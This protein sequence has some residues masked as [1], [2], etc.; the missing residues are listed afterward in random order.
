M[1]KTKEVNKL[2]EIWKKIEGYEDLYVV[3]NLGKIKNMVTGRVLKGHINKDGYTVIT[4]TKDKKPKYF[5][6]HR[7]VAIHFIDN[8]DNKAE[9]DHIIP[10]SDGGS[11]CVDNLRWATP[12]ENTNNPISKAKT[13]ASKIGRKPSPKATERAKEVLIID[14]VVGIGKDGDIVIFESAEEA[15][16]NGFRHVLECCRGQRKTDKG[17]KWSFYSDAIANGILKEEE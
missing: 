1:R 5:Y 8:P 17:Y 16:R 12:K 13:D 14:S 4:L 6:L 3:S 15:K 9:V 7:I 11:N 2:E 10:I